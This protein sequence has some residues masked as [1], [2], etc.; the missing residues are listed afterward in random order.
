MPK[1][2]LI[3]N[4]IQLPNNSYSITFKVDKDFKEVMGIRFSDNFSDFNDI[5]KTD[6]IQELIYFLDNKRVKHF[7]AYYAELRKT[8]QK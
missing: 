2:N 7:K 6:I 3:N 5:E 1:L 8:K 4:V